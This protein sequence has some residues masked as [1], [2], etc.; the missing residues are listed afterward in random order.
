MGLN[1]FCTL[2]TAIQSAC[3]IKLTI[4]LFI[5]FIFSSIPHLLPPTPSSS[6]PLS[7]L[8]NVEHNLQELCDEFRVLWKSLLKEDHHASDKERDLPQRGEGVERCLESRPHPLINYPCQCLENLRILRQRER[9]RVHSFILFWLLINVVVRCVLC[10]H[11]LAVGSNPTQGS[12]L[13]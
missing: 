11:C 12:L 10:L 9:E 7:S 3:F 1:K 2:A 13:F 6:L 4:L 5:T 8:V